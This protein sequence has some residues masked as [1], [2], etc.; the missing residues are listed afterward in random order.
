M[1]DLESRYII[2]TDYLCNFLKLVAPKASTDLSQ[3][4][5]VLDNK[6]GSHV[7]GIGGEPTP[8]AVYTN[9]KWVSEKWN[10]KQNP[11]E[12]WIQ[13]GIQTA[14]PMIQEIMSGAISEED[15]KLTL[16]TQ[17]DVWQQQH[18]DIV[19]KLEKK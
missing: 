13:A 5:R 11:N 19:S 8:Y 2:A 4:I 10:G 16:D 6:K 17:K 14:M 1:I 15:L 12:G 7:I 3:N 18:D 9:E